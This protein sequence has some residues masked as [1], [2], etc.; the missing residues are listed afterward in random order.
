[1]LHNYEEVR[2]KAKEFG[3]IVISVAVAQ[4]KEVLEAVK[5][6]MDVGLAK[7][8]LVGDAALIKPLLAEAG[9][10]A[11]TPIVHESDVER[12]A[13][14]ATSLVS[15]GKAQVLMKGL[16]NSGD[17]LK[18]VLNRE[19]G[20]RTGR[21]LCHFAAFEDPNGTKLLYHSDGGMN[22]APDLEAKKQIITSCMIALTALGI[23]QPKVA[24]L[25]ANEVVNPK[26]QATMDAKALVDLHKAGE[27][28]PESI[29][30]GPIAMDVALSPEAAK[31]KGLISKIA[32]D[33]DL[34]IF[35]TIEAGNLTAKALIYYAKFKNSGVI[36]GA[37][38]PIVMVSRSDHAES[39][40][41]SIALACLLAG[42]AANLNS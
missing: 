25:A 9:L 27:L 40:L 19:V 2:T 31:H 7:V 36:L 13:L 17:F 32:G 23:K 6:A 34:F 29:I 15:I 24:I 26:M 28:F 1:M 11:D 35:P 21:T 42:R 16:I 39:K 37:T 14:T 22:I 8:I 3:Q 18:A 41:N 33:V 12:A 4:D 38:H 5:A 20:L 10:P 30:E